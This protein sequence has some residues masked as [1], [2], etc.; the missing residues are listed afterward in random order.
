MPGDWE[1]TLR[2]GVLLAILLPLLLS[3]CAATPTL[4]PA[5]VFPATS[6]LPTACPSMTPTASPAP[7]R[8]RLPTLTP[9]PRSR[10]TPTPTPYFPAEATVPEDWPPLPADLY[11]LRDGAL[12]RWPAEGGALQHM[13]GDSLVA[14]RVTPDGRRVVYLTAEGRYYLLDEGGPGPQLLPTT[15]HPLVYYTTL[16]HI[17]NPDLND[18]LELD[19][20][21]LTSDG[22]YLVYIAWETASPPGT[23]A[24]STPL[25][26]PAPQVRGTLYA[27]DLGGGEQTELGPC[28]DEGGMGTTACEGLLLSPDGTQVAYADAVG[29]WVAQ[30]PSGEPRLLAAHIEPGGSPY[31]RISLPH[32]WS[33]D[34]RWLLVNVAHYE[35]YHLAVIEIRSGMVQDLPGV[36]CYV[37]CY[38]EGEW[39]G[40][41]LVVATIG[42][43]ETLYLARPSEEGYLTVQRLLSP[44]QVLAYAPHSWPMRRIVST[45]CPTAGWPLLISVIP[46][47]RRPRPASMPLPLMGASNCWRL[48]PKRAATAGPM[49]AG[50]P[51]CCGRL[52]LPPSFT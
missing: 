19:Q 28:T 27:W 9:S 31:S 13:A 51:K 43:S 17:M 45:R 30:V 25:P 34:S 38:A 2:S 7:T 29:L 10:H 44:E 32:A 41:T 26:T 42:I 33:P 47:H 14:Y 12:W 21:A 23:A 1:H 11:F 6:P 22:R 46:G 5:T 48:W 50:R 39:A 37:T 52:L 35:G 36:F 49:I 3:G 18:L 15:G 40:D 16:G 4:P 24:P 20:F 8:T